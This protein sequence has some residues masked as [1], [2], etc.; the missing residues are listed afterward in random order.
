MLLTGRPCCEDCAAAALRFRQLGT[1]AASLGDKCAAADWFLLWPPGA[2][3]FF[4]SDSEAASESEPFP[5]ST[6]DFGGPGLGISECIHLF[7]K[8]RTKSR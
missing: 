7:P 6:S 3:V 5:V 1:A 4:A 2:V 8:L